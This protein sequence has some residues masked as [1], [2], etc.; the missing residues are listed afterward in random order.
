LAGERSRC[1]VSIR[2]LVVSSDIT[3][4]LLHWLLPVEQLGAPWL[5]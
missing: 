3:T 5:V 1:T 4:A 2:L